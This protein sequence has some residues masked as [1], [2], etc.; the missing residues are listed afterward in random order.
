MTV[1]KLVFVKSYID[2]VAD[3]R[4]DRFKYQFPLYFSSDLKLG[5]ANC[6]FLLIA[7]GMS[8]DATSAL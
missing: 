2:T 3:V 8:F 1:E 7:Y 6:I 5:M 4:I